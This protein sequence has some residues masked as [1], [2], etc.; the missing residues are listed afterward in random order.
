MSPGPP[1]PADGQDDPPDV[2]TAVVATIRLLRAVHD[3][4]G[5]HPG[6]ADLADLRERVGA[7][8]RALVRLHAHLDEGATP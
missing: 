7:L 6:D 2:R 3:R 1:E 5:D 4:L 8:R